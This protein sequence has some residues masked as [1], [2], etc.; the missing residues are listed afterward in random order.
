MGVAQAT[1]L[2]FLKPKAMGTQMS[3][4][5]PGQQAGVKPNSCLFLSSGIRLVHGRSC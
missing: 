5:A 1:D 4:Q 2:L 3:T